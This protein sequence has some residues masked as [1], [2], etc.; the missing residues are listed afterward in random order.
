MSKRLDSYL[1]DYGFVKSRNVAKTMVLNGDITVNGKVCKKPSFLVCDGDDVKVIGD[2]PKYVG[3]GGLK[4]E[5]ALFEFDIDLNG[6]ICI[7]IGASTGGFTD[8]ML[9]NGALSV[10]AVDVGT[11]QL[12]DTLR[13]DNRVKC[14]ENT[15]VRSLEKSDFDCVIDFAAADVSFISISL[16]L[17]SMRRIV[18]DDGCAVVLIKPQFEA[19]KSNIGKNGIVKDRKIHADVI[20]KCIAYAENADFDI[21]RI[22][23]S[24]ITGT[25]GNIEYLMW[26]KCGYK[27]KY[28][29]DCKAIVKSAFDAN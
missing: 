19:G 1:F 4:L 21:Q 24:P 18:S 26:L 20:E 7:D 12:A 15:D 9:Q 22:I 6:K 14:M 29:Q 27:R 5:K 23:P 10:F 28:V 16:I 13:S 25:S 11:N 17:S 3:R 8:C 2:M